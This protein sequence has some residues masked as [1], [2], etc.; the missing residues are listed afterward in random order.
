MPYTIAQLNQMAQDAFVAVLGT[1]FEATPA[2]AQQAWEQRPFT[3]RTDLHRTMVT[4]LQAM[5]PDAQL[6]LLVAHPDL[7]SKAK[8]APV[9]VQE[10]AGVGLDRLTAQEYD[11]FAQL[12]QT[13]RTQFG[14]PYII[15]VR[16]HTKTSILQSFIE[17]LQNTPEQERQRALAEVA[18]I[19][20]FR[21]VDLVSD[22]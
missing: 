21:L 8:M 16:N 12:N 20:R 19:A 5:S 3:D 11:R 9:S 17:R 1:V 7:G 2:I 4:I 15:A 18:E 10:Q 14:F 6:A 13:Y 22:V